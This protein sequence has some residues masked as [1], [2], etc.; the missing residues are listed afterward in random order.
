MAKLL[1]YIIIK[2]LSLLPLRML[3]FISDGIFF[4]LYYLTP[5]RKKVVLANLRN[6]FP[7]K[8]DTEIKKIAKGFYR[9][10][11]DLIAESIRMFSMSEK[12]VLRRFRIDDV[13][14][15]HQL[16][17]E[18]RSIILTGGHY[19]NWE[20]LA[21]AIN[22]QLPHQVAALY[23]PMRNTFFDTTFLKS[24]SKFGLLMIPKKKVK[25]FFEDNTQNLTATIFGADQSPSTHSKSYYRTR[26][27]NQETA[28]LFGAEKYAMEYNYPVVFMHIHKIKRG[29]YNATSQVVE[30]YPQNA[31][32]GSI[33]KK[34][35]ALLEKEIQNNP[36]FWLWSHKRWKIKFEK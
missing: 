15:H 28:V 13:A 32:Y 36:E 9:H 5:Y 34:H 4:I 17:Q 12:E 21:L 8:N 10:F 29:Y 23:T 7:E 16:Y 19:N 1:Y 31:E 18:G 30:L 24:R 20:M 2:P 26:F 25:E 6:S 27:L 3:Y 14:L 22:Q 35:T 11:V 33:T